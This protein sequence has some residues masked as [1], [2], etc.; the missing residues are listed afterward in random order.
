LNRPPINEAVGKA[1]RCKPHNGHVFQI[2]GNWIYP[3]LGCG[4]ECHTPLWSLPCPTPYTD[5][6]AVTAL[7]TE[8]RDEARKQTAILQ[9]MAEAQGADLEPWRCRFVPETPAP[10][11][12]GA[13]AKGPRCSLPRGHMGRCQ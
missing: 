13:F 7:L 1:E 11:N 12:P 4:A 2:I 9:A 5:P 3:C 10:D 6:V 8:I